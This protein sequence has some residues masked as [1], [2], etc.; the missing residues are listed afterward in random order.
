MRDYGG[1][2]V[3]VQQKNLPE[4]DRAFYVSFTQFDSFFYAGD[5]KAVDTLFFEH[6]CN[7]DCSV[8]VCVRLD[9]ADHFCRRQRPDELEVF[10]QSE[11]VYRGL[12]WAAHL[13]GDSDP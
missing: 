10:A 12:G 13:G 9:D 3:R 5:G 4:S 2:Q 6:T 7:G 11:K 1:L 8:T